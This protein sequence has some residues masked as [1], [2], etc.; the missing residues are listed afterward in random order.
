MDHCADLYALRVR[1][2]GYGLLVGS[3]PFAGRAPHA[4]VAAHLT[5][6]PTPLSECRPVVAPSAAVVV[7]RPLPKGAEGRP[8]TP[9]RSFVHSIWSRR[10]RLTWPARRNCD[11]DVGLRGPLVCA[12]ASVPARFDIPGN[13]REAS[14]DTSRFRNEYAQTGLPTAN[15]RSIQ[16]RT[17]LV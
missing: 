11:I 10:R 12:A 2:D 9:R 17:R 3:H 1:R 14:A 16:M 13:A 7:M 4:A 8:E 5:E 15:R 6:A